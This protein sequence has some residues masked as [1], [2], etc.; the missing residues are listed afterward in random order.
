[1]CNGIHLSKLENFLTGNNRF[2]DIERND[3]FIA[4]QEQKIIHLLDFFS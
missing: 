1:M 4:G 3:N 2:K